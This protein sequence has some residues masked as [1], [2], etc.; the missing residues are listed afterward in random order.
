MGLS[1]G[2]KT[3][4]QSTTNMSG[5]ST[6]TPNVPDWIK[7]P[8]QNYY[9]QLGSFMNNGGPGQPIGP[10]QNQQAAFDGAGG[11]SGP[12]SSLN[13]AQFFTRGLL[14]YRPDGLKPTAERYDTSQHLDKFMNPFQQNVIDNSLAD[15]QRFG[16]QQITNNQAGATAA[17]AYGGSRHG[18]ADALTNSEL[19]RNAGSL[20][21][22]LN[23]QNFN[24]ALAA[25]Q[26]EVDRTMSGDMFNRNLG[27]QGAQF[28]G[29]MASQLGQLG[30]SEDGNT[31]A[32]LGLLSGLGGEERA[33]QQENDPGARQMQYMARIAAL[34][35]AGNPE[36]FTGQT[37]TQ[38]G[39]SQT[40]GWNQ[41]SM[42]LLGLLGTMSNGM[43]AMGNMMPG[44]G[45]G[46]K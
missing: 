11:L 13:R 40:Q 21:S 5:T 8:Y 41:Q 22:T 18:V 37:G 4:E 39:T 33:I 42:G 10:T 7:G 6:T 27:L 16:D 35:G 46:G 38:T 26:G 3:R 24:Q 44:M 31:R 19:Q 30:L 28:R 43:G 36:L 20:T 9:S 45:G 1:G 17:G 15:L 29:Q 14:D 2:N 12:N 32:N 25:R 23:A 34:L